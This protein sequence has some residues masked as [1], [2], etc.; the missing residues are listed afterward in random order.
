MVQQQ[1][2]SWKRKSKK[3]KGGILFLAAIIGIPSGIYGYYKHLTTK[4]IQGQW[5]ITCHINSSSYRPYIG[6]SSG[7]KIY[8]IQEQDKVKGK[9][10]MCWVD[11]KEIP[12]SQ[13]VPIIVEGKVDGKKIIL[14]Y[15]QKGEKRTTVGEIDLSA[16]SVNVF[17]GTFS[18]TAADTKGTAIAERME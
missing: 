6:K 3:I 14:N 13:H 12:Y 7:F 8:F 16:N 9:G 15:T 10:E 18:G 17:E 1:Q 5:K 11:D 2:I 4:S